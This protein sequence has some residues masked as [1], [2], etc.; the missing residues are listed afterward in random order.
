MRYRRYRHKSRLAHCHP[1]LERKINENANREVIF[2]S[3]EK[4][5]QCSIS[6][7][8]QIKT[9]PTEDTEL[10]FKSASLDINLR[11]KFKRSR[12]HHYKHFKLQFFF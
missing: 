1:Q 3:N 8:L 9:Q 6:T 11:V 4:E 5:L 10:K 7:Y 12:N 2:Y